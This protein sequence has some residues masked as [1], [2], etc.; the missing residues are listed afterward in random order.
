MLAMC[1]LR[2]DLSDASVG[3]NNAVR[4]DFLRN[5]SA[6]HLQQRIE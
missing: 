2:G 1:M 4:R 3:G 5:Y 6:L